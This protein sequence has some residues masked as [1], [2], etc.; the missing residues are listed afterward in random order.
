MGRWSTYPTTVN[1]LREIDISFLSKHDYLKP[2]NFRSGVITWSYSNGNKNSISIHTV[3]NE[4]DGV[5]TL[6]YTYNNTEKI[7]YQ[8]Q[9]ITRP[10]NLGKGLIWFFV[11]P[12][13]GKVCRKLH[14]INGYFKHRSALSGIMYKSQIE[15]KKWRE[16][17]KIFKGDFDDKIYS[18]L[19]SKGFKKFY[20]G[21]M[22]KRYL[23]ICKKIN[24]SENFDFREFYKMF[25]I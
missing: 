13:T 22:T 18:E 17:S 8:I 7:N 11:C 23:R 15:S 3:T 2:D 5:L 24:E 4:T 12:Y 21:K 19:Y 14:L 1:D 25:G 6:D 9:L 10:S 16:W 20:A